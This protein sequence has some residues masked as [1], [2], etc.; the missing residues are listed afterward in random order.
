MVW[1]GLWDTNVIGPFFFETTVDGEKYLFM[2]GNQMMP[3]LDEI[4]GRPEWFMQDGAPPHYAI[5]VRDWLDDMFP[6]RWIERRG[7]TIT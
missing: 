1:C 7:L 6:D 5:R 4:G 3:D 2:L